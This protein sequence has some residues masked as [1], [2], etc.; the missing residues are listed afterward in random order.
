MAFIGI[1]PGGSGGIAIIADRWTRAVK[2]PG[3]PRDILEAVLSVDTSEAF[4]MLETVHAMPKQGVSSTFKFGANYGQLQMALAA[5][6]VR[7][8]EVRPQRW[9]REFGLILP[10]LSVTE[11]KNAHKARAQQLFPDAKVT[12]AIADAL[13]IAEY[14]RR[15]YQ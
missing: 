6:G 10:K 11:K 3:T 5:S 4:A 1:D 9:Q 8:E 7:W 2:M 12:H 15:T 14:C 13:L